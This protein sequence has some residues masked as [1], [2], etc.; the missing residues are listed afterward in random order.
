[1]SKVL[2]EDWSMEWT[3]C[4]D[5]QSCGSF[6]KLLNLCTVFSNDSDI[7]TACFAVPVFFY[8]KCS[9]FTETVC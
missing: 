9:E 1:M 3:D 8:V 6:Q 4:L 2:C 5:I 7:V